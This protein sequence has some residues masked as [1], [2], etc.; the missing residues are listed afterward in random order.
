M[1]AVNNLYDAACKAVA[2]ALS[3]GIA[4]VDIHAEINE[5]CADTTLAA[6]IARRLADANIRVE[7]EG[8]EL[9]KFFYELER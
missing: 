5:A 9:R 6:S 4:E 7:V 3:A 8:N 2:D 1:S